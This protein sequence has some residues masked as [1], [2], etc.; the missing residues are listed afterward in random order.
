MINR[1]ILNEQVSWTAD[2]ESVLFSVI[3]Y[4]FFFVVRGKEVLDSTVVFVNLVKSV[5]V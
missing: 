2:C 1:Y 5:G 4:A 3:Q